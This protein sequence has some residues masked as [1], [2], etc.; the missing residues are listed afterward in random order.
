M[1]LCRRPNTAEPARDPHG[2]AAWLAHA[3]HWVFVFC[4]EK[5]SGFVAIVG[6][7]HMTGWLSDWFDPVATIHQPVRVT[8]L[9]DKSILS[10]SQS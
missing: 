3:K 9:E 8:L 7:K 5:M 6:W 4:P 1:P 2:V 10:H